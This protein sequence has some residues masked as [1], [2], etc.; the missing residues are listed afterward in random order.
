MLVAGIDGSWSNVV[1][2]PLDRLPDW[3][4]ELGMKPGDL[5]PWLR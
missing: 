2:L 4:L 3:I 5:L 1:G